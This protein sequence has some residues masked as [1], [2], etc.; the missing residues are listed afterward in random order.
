MFS[1]SCSYDPRIDFSSTSESSDDNLWS[2]KRSGSIMNLPYFLIN[3]FLSGEIRCFISTSK[4]KNLRISFTTSI[5]VSNLFRPFAF[6]MKSGLFKDFEN[7]VQDKLNYVMSWPVCFFS[8]ILETKKASRK[9]AF[10]TVTK[11]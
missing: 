4:T 6:V 10:Q 9:P 3:A 5:Y 11:A 1:C 8:N 7:D 2:S